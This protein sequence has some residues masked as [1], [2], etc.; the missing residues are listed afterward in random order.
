MGL[1]GILSTAVYVIEVIIGV[2]LIIFVH[3][4]GHYLAAKWAGVKVRRFFFGFAPVIRIGKRKITLQ[5]FAIERGGTKYGVGM[6]PFGGFVDMAGEHDGDEASDT[7]RE[8][9]FNSKTPGQRAVIFA[10]GATMNAISAILFFVISF[11]IGVSFVR[12]TVGDV[13]RGGPAWQA[14]LQPGDKILEVNGQKQSEFTEMYMEVALADADTELKFK[15]QR[16]EEIFDVEIAPVPDLQGRGMTIGI[17]PNNLPVVGLIPEGSPADKAGLKADDRILSLQYEDPDSGETIT[18]PVRTGSD[19]TRTTSKPELVGKP[20]VFEIERKRPDRT[21]NLKVRVVPEIPEESPKLLGIT[22]LATKVGAIQK[23]SAANGIFQE[24]DVIKAVQGIPYCSFRHLK[25]S[26]PAGDELAVELEREA[27]PVKLTVQKKK[28]LNW[29]ENEMAFTSAADD[30]VIGV[31]LPG[32]PAA[33]AGIRPGDRVTKVGGEKMETFTDVARAI[34]ARKG[35]PVEITWQREKPDGGSEEFTATLTPAPNRRGYIGIYFTQDRFILQKGFFGAIG[36]GISRTVLWA[37]RVF[38]I[39]KGLFTR[40]ISPRNLAGPV[41]IFTISYAVTQFGLGTLIYFLA[42]I[43][44]NLAI[45]NI[46]PI[47]VLDGGHLLF[48]LIEK[49]KGSPV[50]LKTQVMAQ[51]V[52]LVLLLSMAVFVTYNDIARLITGW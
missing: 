50:A 2:S 4:L 18:V 9:Q 14:G 32:M 16:G 36:T 30:P 38:L 12:P 28:L 52:G 45:L 21:K 37:K 34:A 1:T 19:V 22:G 5:F 29:L 48:L 10:A 47:P 40:D 11:A 17:A 20:V 35:E 15:I 7:P 25:A 49:I 8:Q 23:G 6:I 43:S 51:T 42:M 46:F 3:E 26:L 24:G 39:V 44:I 31:V 13:S 41:G 27:G 33:K